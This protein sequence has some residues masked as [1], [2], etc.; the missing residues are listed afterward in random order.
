M[1]FSLRE[2]TRLAAI[3]DGIGPDEEDALYQKARVLYQKGAVQPVEAAGRGQTARYDGQSA[4]MVR[5]LLILGDVGVSLADA[6]PFFG[7][8]NLSDAAPGI[9]HPATEFGAALAGIQNGEEWELRIEFRRL[10]GTGERELKGGFRR[11]GEQA[12]ALSRQML[13]DRA[14]LHATVVVPLALVAPFLTGSEG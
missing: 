9:V 1:S 11:V 2:I 6:R 13:D 4:A 3:A 8:P 10:R 5:L 7:K 14:A 12:N